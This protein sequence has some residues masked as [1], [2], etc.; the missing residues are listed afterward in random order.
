VAVSLFL[1]ILL[2]FRRS[3]HH[4]LNHTSGGRYV[5]QQRN[6]AAALT[7]LLQGIDE[8]NRRTHTY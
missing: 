2:T 6:K 7:T 8:P 3:V 1:L 5:R 4:P